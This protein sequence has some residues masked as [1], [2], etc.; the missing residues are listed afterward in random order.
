[1][2]SAFGYELLQEPNNHLHIINIA[3]LLSVYVLWKL[4]AEICIV[5]C[6]G[7]FIDSAHHQA[8]KMVAACVYSTRWDN[9][10]IHQ[11]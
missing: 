4:M 11:D 9:L 5:T 6:E 3:Y 2:V 8:D 10:Q 1:M 7:V